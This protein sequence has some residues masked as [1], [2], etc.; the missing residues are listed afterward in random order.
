[1]TQNMIES[2]FRLKE[3]EIYE[4][5]DELFKD[6]EAFQPG[7]EV[8][9]ED[10]EESRHPLPPRRMS[11]TSS[12][13]KN[14]Q[15]KVFKDWSLAANKSNSYARPAL[16]RVDSDDSDDDAAGSPLE[17]TRTDR[18]NEQPTSPTAH[19]PSTA[20]SDRKPSTLGFDDDTTDSGQMSTAQTAGVTFKKRMTTMYV[21]LM[22]LKSYVQ[23]N[24]TGFSKILKKYD[25]TLDRSLK[26]FYL[27]KNVDESYVFSSETMEKLNG[28]IN[29]LEQSYANLNTGGNLDLARR[30]LKLDVRE[31]VVWER[32]TVWRE[33]IG[34]ERKAQ[35]AWSKSS[36]KRIHIEKEDPCGGRQCYRS[37]GTLQ[38][39]AE[40]GL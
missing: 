39:V 3:Q 25:K 20:K 7:Q 8:L 5:I 28:H 16:E 13:A 27:S 24:R 2:F 37:E 4:E 40:Q 26:Q 29:R 38:T 35:A 22:E 1:M 14:R 33:M 31:K 12:D 6:E 32:N 18:S 34:I 30:E 10:G 21:M 11:R 17:R 9:I 23:L 36:N 19:R 15:Q